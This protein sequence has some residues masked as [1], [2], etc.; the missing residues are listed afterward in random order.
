MN[1]NFAFLNLILTTEL[2]LWLKQ[3]KINKSS[4]ELIKYHSI[5]DFFFSDE[6]QTCDCVSQFMGET[7]VYG[8]VIGGDLKKMYC[9]FEESYTWTVR[10]A[11]ALKYNG[12]FFFF[13][14]L[15]PI[16]NVENDILIF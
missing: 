13:K 1:D 9:S 8:I 4:K 2:Q 7:G 6:C 11:L 16:C 5:V 3:Y 15:I 10:K 12:V 14:T